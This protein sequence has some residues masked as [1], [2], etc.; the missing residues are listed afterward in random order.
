M[1]SLLLHDVKTH[2]QISED[3]RLARV[4]FLGPKALGYWVVWF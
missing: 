3:T 4:D 1:L 2:G